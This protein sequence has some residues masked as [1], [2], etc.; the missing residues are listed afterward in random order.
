M[1]AETVWEPKNVSIPHQNSDE[2]GVRGK[3]ITSLIFSIPVAN[4]TSL[5]KPRPKP[6]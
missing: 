4:C 2:P 6:A 3:G 1:G 5:S